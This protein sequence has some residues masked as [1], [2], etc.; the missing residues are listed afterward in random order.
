MAVGTVAYSASYYEYKFSY[1][2]S[3][4]TYNASEK[5]E[6]IEDKKEAVETKVE[7][8]NKTENKDYKSILLEHMEM[9]REKIKKG[10]IEEKFP[11]GNSYYTQEEWDKLLESFD[12]T[13]QDINLGSAYNFNTKNEKG[14]NVLHISWT[15]DEGIFC[16]KAGQTEGYEWSYLF[17]D[18]SQREQVEK[19]I[20]SLEKDADLETIFTEEFWKKYFEEN[21]S[22]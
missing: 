20:Q 1:T 7:S 12:D 18:P 8:E 17:T 5:T 9:M 11:I 4:I 15:T 6:C 21:S 22:K 16:R 13:E 3:K 2:S 14:E 10:D 19:Y